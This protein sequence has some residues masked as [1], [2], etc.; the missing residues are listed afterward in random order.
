[1]QKAYALTD[2]SDAPIATPER[3]SEVVEQFHPLLAKTAIQETR[4]QSEHLLDDGIEDLIQ[5]AIV[6]VL[7]RGK[8]EAMTQGALLEYLKTSVKRATANYLRG[9]RRASIA[10][11]TI[12]HQ[13]LAT[14]TR[15]A[16]VQAPLP[17][18][19]GSPKTT[20]AK[21]HG[22]SRIVNQGFSSLEDHRP[23][24]AKDHEQELTTKI[25]VAEALDRLPAELA[26]IVRLVYC[27]GHAMKEV[28]KE[29]G[30]SLRTAERRLS[31]A[32]AALRSLL[33]D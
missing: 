24:P 22:K 27:E 30:I 2:N 15:G 20:K 21:G 8:W 12:H 17:F 28:A 11:A 31:D 16:R 33:A 6:N 13:R 3:F 26:E 19:E 1:V 25:V 29:L 32:R 18:R 4:R 10:K 9:Q 5:N 7:K 14:S 23:I